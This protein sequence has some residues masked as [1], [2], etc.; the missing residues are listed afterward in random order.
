MPEGHSVL[1]AEPKSLEPE[2]PFLSTFCC[3]LV[4]SD[5]APFSLE[6]VDNG[7]SNGLEGS[8]R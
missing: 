6:Q 3:P 4:P 2:P 7:T 5:Q 1:G 8:F